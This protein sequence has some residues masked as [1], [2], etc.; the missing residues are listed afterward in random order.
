MSICLPFGYFFLFI[1]VKPALQYIAGFCFRMVCSKGYTPFPGKEQ[2]YS[3]LPSMSGL[4][5]KKIQRSMRTGFGEAWTT[6]PC[7]LRHKVL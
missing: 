2:F 1:P 4:Y 6:N 3:V 7:L 5:T